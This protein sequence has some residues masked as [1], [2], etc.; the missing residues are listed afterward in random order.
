[1]PWRSVRTWC[2]EPFL[3]RSVG[4]GPVFLPPF[5]PAR[6]RRPAKRDSRRAVP[7]GRVPRAHRLASGPRRRPSSNRA[8]GANTSCPNSRA[9]A[10][11]LPTADRCARRAECRPGRHDPSTTGGRLFCAVG[12]A[13]GA[14]RRG[15]RAHRERGRGPC[16]RPFNLCAKLRCVRHSKGQAADEEVPL[17]DA[18]A[19]GATQPLDARNA[20]QVGEVNAEGAKAAA[21]SE[22]ACAPPRLPPP[23]A[24]NAAKAASACC[25]CPGRKGCSASC[26]D[27]GTTG[28]AP[29]KLA[30]RFVA[31][32]SAHAL[33]L[34]PK[35]RGTGSP[36]RPLRSCRRAR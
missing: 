8:T 19:F 30:K 16:P 24:S 18:G 20:A 36:R 13:A 11:G 10:A 23:A 15:T 17:V 22:R 14:V 35:R 6:S 28:T 34:R 5:L 9:P 21:S 29:L 33:A 4:F 12:V 32:T 7:F 25:G 26:G 2:L 27:G 31:S 1:M 3:P